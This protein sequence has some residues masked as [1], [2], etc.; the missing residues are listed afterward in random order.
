M[1][2]LGFFTL[3]PFVLLAFLYS[4]TFLACQL[5]L[6]KLILLGHNNFLEDADCLNRY[7]NFV[8]GLE[9]FFY[10]LVHQIFQSWI[11]FFVAGKLD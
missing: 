2:I 5:C 11:C 8:F 3:F 6:L 4:N 1:L 10:R 9:E 7:Q